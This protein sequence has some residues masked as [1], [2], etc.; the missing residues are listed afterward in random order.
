M[1]SIK[2]LG[3]KREQEWKGLWSSAQGHEKGT[4][5]QGRDGVTRRTLNWTPRAESLG[6]QLE[7]TLF[8]FK[9]LTLLVKSDC[10][11]HSSPPLW[12]YG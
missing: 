8:G 2:I 10:A 3:V 9:S 4:E 12:H 7:F 6:G 11:N 5:A 1:D